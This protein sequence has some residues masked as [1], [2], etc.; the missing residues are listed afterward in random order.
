[1]VT[2]SFF[3]SPPCVCGAGFGAEPGAACIVGISALLI[4]GT[5]CIF[6][7]AALSK[8]DVLVD[9]SFLSVISNSPDLTLEIMN[10]TVNVIASEKITPTK[11][12]MMP[13]II[14]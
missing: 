7:I 3:E 12:L 14:E 10:T 4:S 6:G 8:N 9:E 11:T 2:Q 1:M 13:L 5:L